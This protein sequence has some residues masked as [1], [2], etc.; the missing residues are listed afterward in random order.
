MLYAYFETTR[1]VEFGIAAVVAC[2]AWVQHPPP[3]QQG[4]KA[5]K[6]VTLT[7]PNH[8]LRSEQDLDILLQE[9]GDARVVLLGEASHGTAEYYT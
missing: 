5:A 2:A 7:I 4:Q 8:P 1:P 6:T 9:I 3:Q